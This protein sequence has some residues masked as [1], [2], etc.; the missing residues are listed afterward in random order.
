[1]EVTAYAALGLAASKEHTGL[2]MKALSHLLSIR[3]NGV[4]HNTHSTAV[5]LQA[6]NLEG[7]FSAKDM[8]IAVN[9]GGADAGSMHLTRDNNDLVFY[10]DLRPFLE[11]DNSTDLSISSSGQGTV[12]YQLVYEENIPW[13]AGPGLGTELSL[14]VRPGSL[15]IATGNGT[16]I[17][18]TVQ[19]KG[20]LGR[21]KM[22]LVEIPLPAGF[23]FDQSELEDLMA[24]GRVNGFELAGGRLLRFYIDGLVPNAP[25]SFSFHV[26][27]QCAGE[28][29]MQGVRAYDMYET[30]RSTT[31]AP[32]RFT[33]S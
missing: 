32:M 3:E 11:A 21:L 2:V 1:V 5:A 28:L 20:T 31:L 6:L 17:E 15:S 14:Q 8:T 27:A 33:V 12:V 22:V 16:S 30:E 29:T 24:A 13:D 10:T 9:A 4:W 25:A 7:A 18:V 26:V 19:Y 23:S